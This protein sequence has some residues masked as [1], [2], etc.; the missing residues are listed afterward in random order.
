MMFQAIYVDCFVQFRLGGSNVAP[1]ILV[2][3]LEPH[4]EGSDAK[5]GFD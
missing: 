2:S 4:F 3:D 1:N 5:E